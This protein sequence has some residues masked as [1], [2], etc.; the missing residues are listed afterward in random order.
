MT[1]VF[2]VSPLIVLAKS[3]LLDCFLTLGME[4]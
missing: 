4:S 1:L 3:G 2:N